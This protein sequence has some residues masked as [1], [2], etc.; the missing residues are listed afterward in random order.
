MGS[1]L[2]VANLNYNS[3]PEDIEEFFAEVGEVEEVQLIT[4]RDTGRS[5]GFAFVT[6]A[7]D[8]DAEAAIE[9]LNGV[10]FSGRPLVV[11]EARPR[12]DRGGGGG[13]SGGPPRG[14][15][16]GGKP[17]GKG[18]GRDGGGWSGDD[19]GDDWGGSKPGG[20]GKKKGKSKPKGGG[21]A[22]RRNR[23]GSWSEWGDSDSW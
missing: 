10:D 20:K 22:G 14:G 13:R 15:G 18:R 19:W 7:N 5:R 8:A 3:T 11:K 4:D 17:K 6:M 9:N 12:E 2:Y 23:G 21:G 1:K 16:G